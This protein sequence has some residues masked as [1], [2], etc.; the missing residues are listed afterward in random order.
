MSEATTPLGSSQLAQIGTYVKDHLNGW[1]ARARHRQRLARR[2]MA[3]FA[4]RLTAMSAGARHGARVRISRT[5]TCSRKVFSNAPEAAGLCVR[6]CRMAE[7][8]TGRVDPRIADPATYVQ[9]I[10]L[11]VSSKPLAPLNGHPGFILGDSE[12]TW[13]AAAPTTTRTPQHRSIRLCV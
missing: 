3:A 2:S 4:V 5:T 13:L 6:I 1:L 12:A 11:P 8:W 10:R 9:I 7:P